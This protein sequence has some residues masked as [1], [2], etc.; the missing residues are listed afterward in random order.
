M[1]DENV[2]RAVKSASTSLNKSLEG[3]KVDVQQSK[4]LLTKIVDFFSQLQNIERNN[5]RIG[6]HGRAV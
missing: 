3:L 5:R 2:V 4:N 1:S 6:I